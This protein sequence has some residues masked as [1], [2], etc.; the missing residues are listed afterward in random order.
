M[1]SARQP[2]DCGCRPAGGLRLAFVLILVML[3][4]TG[5]TR[6]QQ[7]ARLLLE[8]IQAGERPSALKVREPAPEENLT[9]TNLGDGRALDV[10]VVQPGDSGRIRG[11]MILVPGLAPDGLDDPRL[12]T[13]ARSLARVGFEVVI[14]ELPGTA[15][16]V[17][18]R[19]DPDVLAAVVE[20]VTDRPDTGRVILAGVSYA[21]GPAVLAATQPDIAPLTAAIFGVGG[22]YDIE[23][24]IGY[25]T[26]GMYRDPDGEWQRG[27]V[28]QRAVWRYALANADRVDDAA[29]ADRLREIA[30]RRLEDDAGKA[31]D[32]LGPEAAAIY[33]LLVNDD[34]QAVPTLIGRLPAGMRE[35]LYAL[36]PA[37]RQGPAQRV[38]MILVHGRDDP[39]V[40]APEST[41]LAEALGTPDSRVVTA[42]SLGH[43]GFDGSLGWG[44]RL[45]LLA[46]ATDLLDIR[47]GLAGR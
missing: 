21:L 16:L 34:P 17:A 9:R 25:L 45:R 22:Y 5:C 30:A 44:D 28:D 11:T 24:A 36:S 38:R 27:P 1:I 43:A 23:T 46:A 19:S 7:E 37:H 33:N 26:T 12:R 6:Q 10:L 29:D 20:T 40:P 3:V 14:P 39:L 42:A 4:V 13:L 15:D 18:D 41:R 2:L 32:A 8:D 35:D 31:V 47:D